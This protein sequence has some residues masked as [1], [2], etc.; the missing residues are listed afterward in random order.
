[1]PMVSGQEQEWITYEDPFLGIK[2]QHPSDWTKNI[3]TESTV[4]FY[5]MEI[6]P[7][8]FYTMSI[9]V[10]DLQPGNNKLDTVIRD[11]LGPMRDEAGFEL[12]EYNRTAT[13][14]G[15]PAYKIAWIAPYDSILFFKVVNHF[16][17]KDNIGYTVS[18][19]VIDPKKENLDKALQSQMPT[20][21]R[22]LS[23]FAI[24]R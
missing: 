5:K 24:V 11:T 20:F 1:M 2:V 18:F 23:S 4:G 15:I 22:M 14:A 13:L 21:Q 17:I 16:A 12:V 6:Q 7:P 10:E 9:R 8:G 3:T 19:T